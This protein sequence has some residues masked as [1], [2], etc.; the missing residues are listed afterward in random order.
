MR[1]IT[2]LLRQIHPG[3]VQDGRVTSQ[4]FRP[5]PKDEFHLSV[6]NGDTIS[7]ETAW[8]RFNDTQS[9]KSVGVQAVSKAEC[10]METLRVIA[11]GIPHPEHCSIDFTGFDRKTI[12]K[13]AKYLRSQAEKRGWLLFGCKR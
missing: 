5:T 3:F 12:E 7:P 11:D 13:K 2:L 10:D 1:P 9:C 4:A 8:I 6:D